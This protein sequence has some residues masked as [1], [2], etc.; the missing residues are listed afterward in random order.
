[1][2]HHGDSAAAN[3]A[4]K[5]LIREWNLGATGQYPQGHLNDNDEGE[6]KLAVGT[7]GGKVVM[8]FGKLV[9]WIGFDPEQALTLAD[10]L[11]EKAHLARKEQQHGT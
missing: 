9:A 11:R 6:L 1:M 5:R 10:S 4:M 2:A 8:N 7:E 3:E